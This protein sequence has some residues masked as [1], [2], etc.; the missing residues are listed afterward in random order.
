MS[1]QSLQTAAIP[2]DTDREASRFVRWAVAQLQLDLADREDGTA[3]LALP[4][5]ERSAFGGRERIALRFAD[6]SIGSVHYLANGNRGFPKER[7]EVFCGG[8]ILQLDN[9]RVLRGY[10]WKGFRKERLWRQDKG[11]TAEVKAFLEAIQRGGQIP[12]PLE[13]LAEVTQASFVAAEPHA[14]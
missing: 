13:H 12:I 4:E 1:G 10:G 5:E 6:G 8:R 14:S 11:H 3:E 9:F 7:L 2:G